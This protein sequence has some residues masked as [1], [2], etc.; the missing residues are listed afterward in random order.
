MDFELFC[1]L[2]LTRIQRIHPRVGGKIYHTSKSKRMADV[3]SWE[4]L[5]GVYGMIRKATAMKLSALRS[6]LTKPGFGPILIGEGRRNSGG[7]L[8]PTAMGE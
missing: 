1:L 5:T 4:L 8:R 2:Q 6:P 3:D 7:V